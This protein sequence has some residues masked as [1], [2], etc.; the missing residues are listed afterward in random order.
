MDPKSLIDN[1]NTDDLTYE[2][3]SLMAWEIGAVENIDDVAQY[4]W[5]GGPYSPQASA[6]RPRRFQLSEGDPRPQKKYWEFVKQEMYSFLCEE[7][8]K[9]KDL[10]TRLG[11]LEK[12]SSSAMVVLISGY[13]GERAGVEG[14]ILAGFVAVCLYGAAKLSKEALCEYIKANNA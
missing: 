10:W 3:T 13:I 11:K 6:K 2:A 14:S 1:L 8:P 12:K 5:H 7:S 4:M 9:Y